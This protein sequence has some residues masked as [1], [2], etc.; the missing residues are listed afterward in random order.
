VKT[1]IVIEENRTQL[2]LQPE[3]KHDESVL[4]TLEMLPNTHR[5]EFY[6]TQGGWTARRPVYGPSMY[7]EP[8]KQ[9]DLV[10]VFDNPMPPESET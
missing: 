4:T 3:S 9:A 2:V 6:Q 8:K 7:G 1:L 10:I 5:V